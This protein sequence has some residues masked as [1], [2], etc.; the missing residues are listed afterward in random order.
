MFADTDAVGPVETV[1]T[2]FP[3]TFTKHPL[4]TLTKLYVELAVKLGV[5]SV[6]FPEASR[7]IV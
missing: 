7:L 1:I 4:N 5:V 2:A 3:V 6:A